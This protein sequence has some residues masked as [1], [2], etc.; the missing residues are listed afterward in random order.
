MEYLYRLVIGFK[1]RRNGVVATSKSLI[2]KKKLDQFL[3]CNKRT[4]IEV[5][6]IKFIFV[7]SKITLIGV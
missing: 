6:L 5:F 1:I 4:L 2:K 7:T 3:L